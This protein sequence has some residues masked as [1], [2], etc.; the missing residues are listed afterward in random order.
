MNKYFKYDNET[1]KG[2]VVY[3]RDNKNFL[4]F[5]YETLDCDLI[6]YISLTPSIDIIVDEESMLK[7]PID[8]NYIYDVTTDRVIYLTGKLLFV[9]FDNGKTRGINQAEEE[10][11]SNNIKI[12]T[13]PIEV[14]KALR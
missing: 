3:Q 11:I 9:G 14:Y 5:A 6:E 8:I 4:S 12:D 1:M 13:I 2:Q 10:Y 7:S